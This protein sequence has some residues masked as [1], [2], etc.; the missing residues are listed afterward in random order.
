MLRHYII[1]ES[2]EF[3]FKDIFVDFFVSQV[4]FA[5]K[6]VG[7]EEDAK[8]I[9][10]EIFLKVWNGNPEFPNEI[11]FKSYLYISTRNACIDHLRKKRNIITDMDKAAHLEEEA[12]EAMREEAFRLLDKAIETLP[13]QTRNILRLTLSGN[14]ISE[15]ANNLKI[16]VNT[17]KTLK[18]RAYKILREKFGEMFVLLVFPFIQ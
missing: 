2:K 17:V 15:I 3:A 6:I 13:P 16:T 10:Q 9:V 4:H 1:I 8:D 18:Q 7:C 12:N 11:A 14:S 5:S